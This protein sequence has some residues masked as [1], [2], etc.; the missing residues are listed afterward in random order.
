MRGHWAV[1]LSLKTPSVYRRDKSFGRRRKGHCCSV[2]DSIRS[3]SCE[4]KGN[5]IDGY[6]IVGTQNIVK[7]NNDSKWCGWGY[8]IDSAKIGGMHV[9]HVSNCDLI[10]VWFTGCQ[11]KRFFAERH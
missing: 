3:M 7:H 1:T 4:A 2:R 8:F 10:G 6:G 5:V 11:N 9:G